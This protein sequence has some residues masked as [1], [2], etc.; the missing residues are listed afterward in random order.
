M[1]SAFFVEGNNNVN[2]LICPCF[3]FQV[4]HFKL[5]RRNEDL[6]RARDELRAKEATLEERESELQRLKDAEAANDAKRQELEAA[7]MAMQAEQE[8]LEK[9][10]AAM[11]RRITE[12]EM[13]LEEEKQSKHVVVE[14]EVH[15][16]S[17]DD[18]ISIDPAVV[19]SAEGTK[20]FDF[21]DLYDLLS[22]DSY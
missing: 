9:D 3:L 13:M 5:T 21:P 7:Q 6:K 15:L 1:D 18:T 20:E 2:V 12:L 10:K 22:F 11:S 19:D 16:P 4:D 8:K 14:P 17:F